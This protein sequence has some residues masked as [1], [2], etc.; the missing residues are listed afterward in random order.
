MGFQIELSLFLIK[1]YP[2]ETEYLQLIQKIT[3][4]ENN[5]Y[6]HPYLPLKQTKTCFLCNGNSSSH[7]ISPSAEESSQDQNLIHLILN[8]V[9]S[10]NIPIFLSNLFRED[11]ITTC[12]ICNCE[13]EK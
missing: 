13:F 9:S 6:D 8:F 12:V 1:K 2:Q 10:T 3:Q 4:N 7:L 5:K 11:E